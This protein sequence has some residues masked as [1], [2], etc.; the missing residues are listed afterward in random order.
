MAYA[1]P[2]A[3]ALDYATCRYGTS[4][5]LFR[6]PKRC[7]DRVFVAVLG[8]SDCFGRYVKHP[9]PDLLEKEL[10]LPVANFGLP[11][12]GP[13][14][15]LND[16]WIREAAGRAAVTI[17]QVMGAQNISNRY[18]TV[19]P[20]RNDRFLAASPALRALYPK[21]DMT[22]I[23]FTRHLLQTL[24][25]KSAAEF[26]KLALGLQED[27]IRHMHSLLAQISGPT[28]LLWSGNAQPPLQQAPIDLRADHLLVTQQMVEAVASKANR[29][30]YAIASPEA[31]AMGTTG[32][33]FDPLELPFAAQSA[34]PY[35]HRE[36]S[37]TL[38]PHIE[39]LLG[40]RPS[41]RA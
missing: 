36:I 32:M 14:V 41:R 3:G 39:G 7:T 12:A 40:Q 18:F 25:H 22:D 33:D 6:G 11:N 28:I 38:L 26:A 23:H 16:E 13:D 8:G 34:G 35:V 20:R 17:V 21:L 27:W 19:H 30:V 29:M 37:N 15:Y 9:F 2:G 10:G 24:H 4:R 1:F 5:L 31:R